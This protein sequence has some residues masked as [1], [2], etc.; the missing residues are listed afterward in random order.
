MTET[1]SFSQIEKQLWLYLVIFY[2]P[3]ALNWNLKNKNYPLYV[4]VIEHLKDS[5]L[6]DS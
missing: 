2:R 6:F 1:G 3:P 4:D 5:G